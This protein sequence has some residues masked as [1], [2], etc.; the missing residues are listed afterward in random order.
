MELIN[1]M[2]P[3]ATDTAPTLFEL[4]QH[5]TNEL[6]IVRLDKIDILNEKSFDP[7]EVAA[8]A[9]NIKRVGLIHN[10]TVVKDGSRFR[11]ITGARRVAALKLN[12]GDDATAEVACYV[13][14]AKS[15]TPEDIAALVLS[16]NAVRSANVLAELESINTLMKSTGQDVASIAKSTGQNV[17]WIRHRI[18]LNKLDRKLFSHFKHGRVRFETAQQIA[19]LDSAQQSRI[20]EKFAAKLDENPNA[21]L[22]MHDVAVSTSKPVVTLPSSMFAPLPGVESTRDRPAA[23]VSDAPIDRL[24]FVL[25]ELDEL[26]A[27][28]TTLSARQAL[29]RARSRVNVVISELE[30]KG[31]I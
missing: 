13:R 23:A 1:L 5:T 29:T 25:E 20:V 21:V 26:R 31:G 24:R 15:T 2:T 4:T 19:R 9:D 22:A 17:S 7:D 28:M 11:V 10:P 27:T 12:A 14:S 30:E 6:T 3:Q 16:E 8:L 18:V